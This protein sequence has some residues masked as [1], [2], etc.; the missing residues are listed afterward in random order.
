M[1]AIFIEIYGLQNELTPEV[2][3]KDVTIRKA[4]LE[5]DIKSFISYAMAVH[6]VVIHWMKKVLSMLEVRV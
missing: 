4:N 6:L 3:E 5:R 2:E 1:N